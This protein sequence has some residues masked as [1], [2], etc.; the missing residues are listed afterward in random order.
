MSGSNSLLLE[1][2]HGLHPFAGNFVNFTDL[3]DIKIKVRLTLMS[4]N[5]LGGGG[6]MS[7]NAFTHNVI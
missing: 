2:S 6:G 4:A 3:P 5:V 7:V 1:L